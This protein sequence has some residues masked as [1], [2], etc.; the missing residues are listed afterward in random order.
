MADLGIT[1]KLEGLTGLDGAA[2]AELYVNDL[3]GV[4]KQVIAN[5]DDLNAGGIAK[6]DVI[7][8]TGTY[9]V[10]T[11]PA[12]SILEQAILQVS[13]AFNG[14]LKLGKTGSDEAYVADASFVKTV[15][16]TPDP[17]LI[18][19]FLD[20]EMAVKLKVA[21]CTTGAGILWLKFARLP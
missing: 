20:A 9:V 8:T 12:N 5:A 3:N 14:S 16:P 18:G 1:R 13:A 11:L 19:A 2:I 21:G 17:I 7:K 4:M 6:L 15:N 10:A